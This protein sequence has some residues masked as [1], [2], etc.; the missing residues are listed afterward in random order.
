MTN[1][2]RILKIFTGERPDRV[3]WF[4]DLD[5]W[6]SARKLAGSL[7]EKYLGDG[8]FNLN[9]EN[10]C[11]FYLQGYFPFAEIAEGV[12]CHTERL[13]NDIITTMST[14]MGPLTQISRFLPV[15]SSHAF[16][17]HFVEC[18]DDL[19]AFQCYIESL[20]FKPDY[21][22]AERRKGIIGDNGGVLCY[23]PRSPFMQNLTTFFGAQ[24][25][26]LMLADIPGK[27]G[28]LLGLMGEKY[29]QAARLA[30]DSPAEMIM[31]PENLSSE[32][33][34]GYYKQYLRPYEEK[35]IAEIRKA[36]KVS[37]IH[38]DGTLRGLIRQVA[39][40]GFDVI[41]AVTPA[42]VGD[43]SMGELA[44]FVPGNTILWGGAPGIMFTP[45]VSEEAFRSHIIDTLAVM[46]T[47]PRFVLGVADQVPPDGMI[48][49]V[50]A[51][52]ALCD[53]YGRYL[54]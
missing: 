4:A 12:S 20:S 35:W 29:D 14:P 23:T 22:E 32:V 10:G 9:R 33:V 26:L 16:I 5:Y 15:S 39:E 6:Y 21:A 44:A 45:R 34:G 49:R 7:P 51:V 38:M 17:K 1:R 28:A 13:N 41:E 37:F 24:T 11:G 27:I 50:K 48:E 52:S 18:E 36:G 54:G 46:K 8:Y 25:L 31:I 30:V 3:P 43:I 47:A 19:P 2:E 53:E 40:T 42:P